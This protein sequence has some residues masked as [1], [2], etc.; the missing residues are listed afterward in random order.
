MNPKFQN[1]LS[2]LHKTR[3]PFSE[4]FNQYKNNDKKLDRPGGPAIRLHNLSH[5]WACLSFPIQSLLIGIAPS[6]RGARFSGIPFTSEAQLQG[7]KPFSFYNLNP[8]SQTSLG[9]PR[10]ENSAAIVWGTLSR[11]NI[12]TVKKTL[13][14]NVLPFHPH[15]KNQPLSNRDP[16]PEELHYFKPLLLQM[17]SLSRPR[18]IFAVG[19]IAGDFLTT[20]GISSTLLRHP[21]YGGGPR[22]KQQ[23]LRALC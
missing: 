23:L 5:Y 15:K 20:L 7:L 13:L 21:A 3:I 11:M 1:F 9:T 10:S 16:L 19:K 8:F 4:L 6:Y 17:L 14:W 18:R 22:F 2:L 12:N